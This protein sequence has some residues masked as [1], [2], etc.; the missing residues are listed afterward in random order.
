MLELADLLKLGME[1]VLLA[2]M[3]GLWR[4]YQRQGAF[5][6][7]LLMTVID[8]RE[9]QGQASRERQKLGKA[10]GLENLADTEG[11]KPP[12]FDDELRRRGL[13]P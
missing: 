1:G 8:I 4:A 13:I 6:Q 3:L 5:I 12:T 9:Q 7:A 10:V 2:G 11:K